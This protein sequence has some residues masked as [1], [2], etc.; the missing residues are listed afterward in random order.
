MVFFFEVSLE[1]DRRSPSREKP[2]YDY[3][4]PP[5][6]VFPKVFDAGF[7]PAQDEENLVEEADYLINKKSLH[8]LLL[9]WGVA[10]L[11]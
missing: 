9:S 10:S 1:L 2:L 4:S 6:R 8:D 3:D 7:C 11:K 5:F